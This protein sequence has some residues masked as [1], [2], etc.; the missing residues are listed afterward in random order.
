[1]FN[2]I[3]FLRDKI[4]SYSVLFAG[5]GLAVFKLQSMLVSG[6]SEKRLKTHF[7]FPVSLH[8]PFSQ[9]LFER[10]SYSYEYLL[11]KI[12][13]DNAEDEPSKVWSA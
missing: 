7:H 1:M 3:L 4:L 9:F 8:V 2:G 5:V 12:G 10:D 6:V 13:F 11:A